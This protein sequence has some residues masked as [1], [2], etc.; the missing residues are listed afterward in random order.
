MIVDFIIVT[1]IYSFFFV[2][3]Q[4]QK[5]FEFQNITLKLNIEL[6]FIV[7]YEGFYSNNCYLSERMW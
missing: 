5:L 1:I 2:R 7:F 4:K 3:K 6:H